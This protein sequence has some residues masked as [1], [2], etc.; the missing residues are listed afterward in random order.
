MTYISK[1]EHQRE[2]GSSCI[3]Y[4]LHERLIH[5]LRAGLSSDH[6]H[7]CRVSKSDHLP[8][9]RDL[10]DWGGGGVT[11]SRGSTRG[12]MKPIPPI[13]PVA[14]LWSTWGIRGSGGEAYNKPFGHSCDIASVGAPWVLRENQLSQRVVSA[15]TKRSVR[16]PANLGHRRATTS[17]CLTNKGLRCDVNTYHS[18]GG[19][20]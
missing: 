4:V 7:S 3:A 6:A 13:L 14:V 11:V 10:P 17:G 8:G 1:W 20:K 5:L 18:K 15:D 12:C 9:K 16:A 2:D 19:R